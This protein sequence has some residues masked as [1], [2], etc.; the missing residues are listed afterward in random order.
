VL[1]L[2]Q[3]DLGGRADLDDG[4]AAGELR[5]ALLE[6]LAIPVGV[7]VLDLGLDLVDPARDLVLLTAPSTIVVLSLVMMTRLALPS[8]RG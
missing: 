8:S 3:L 7:G 4:D 1:A 6:L 5:E 2:L